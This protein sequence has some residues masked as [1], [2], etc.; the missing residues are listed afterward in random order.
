MSA[1]HNLMNDLM[2]ENWMTGF[3]IQEDI[4]FLYKSLLPER[5]QIEMQKLDQLKNKMRLPA[6]MQN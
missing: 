1:C 3:F 2:I 5:N 6:T 4:F